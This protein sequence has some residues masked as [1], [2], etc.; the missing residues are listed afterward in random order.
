MEGERKWRQSVVGGVTAVAPRPPKASTTVG[1]TCW[2]EAFPFEPEAQRL[3]GSALPAASSSGYRRP[4]S[5]PAH[6]RRASSHHGHLTQSR[7]GAAGRVQSRAAPAVAA[8]EPTNEERAAVFRGVITRK[9][10]ERGKGDRE[11]FY[12]FDRDRNGSVGPAD[13]TR[14]LEGLNLGITHEDATIIF[15][16][17][18]RGGGPAMA[19]VNPSH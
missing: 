7:D 14:A 9:L 5:A 12:F 19:M 1:A 16:Q 15:N 17:C 8:A 10:E 11:A 18:R 2:E 13:F 3:P 4:S 6:A